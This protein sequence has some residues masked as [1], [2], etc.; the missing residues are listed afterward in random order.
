[1]ARKIKKGDQVVVLRGNHRGQRGEV[2]AVLTDKERVLVQ[3]VN[4]VKRHMKA[5]GTQ[6]GGIME[7]EGS[8]AISNV[9][10]VDPETDAPTRVGFTTDDKGQKVRSAR[11]SG[12]ALD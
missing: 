10:L 9:M 11:K 12:K 3:G 2:L 1:M 7:K 5:R 4:I 6:P 8:I